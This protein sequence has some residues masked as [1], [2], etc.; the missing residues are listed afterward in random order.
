MI[1]GTNFNEA[2]DSLNRMARRHAIVVIISDFLFEHHSAV[3]KNP[4]RRTNFLLSPT[5]GPRTMPAL[6]QA[7]RRHDV[8]A[9]QIVDRYE[10]ELPALGRLV[11]TDAE[12][13]EVI[14]I[15]TASAAVRRRFKERSAER[16]R[17]L[18]DRAPASLRR[19]RTQSPLRSFEAGSTRRTRR[20]RCAIGSRPA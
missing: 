8:I 5:L 15:D 16:S 11:L 9:I 13:G 12:T 17:R 19:P 7:N 3:D 6:R 10:L 4:A 14:E 20:R 2:L 1:R 18:A